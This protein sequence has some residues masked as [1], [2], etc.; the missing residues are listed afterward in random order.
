MRETEY[1]EAERYIENG[2]IKYRPKG[3]V[4]PAIT[5]FNGRNKIKKNGKTIRIDIKLISHAG[6]MVYKVTQY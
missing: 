1:L 4:D 6:Q 2:E 5:N 3:K